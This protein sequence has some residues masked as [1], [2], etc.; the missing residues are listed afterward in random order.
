MPIRHT[1]REAGDACRM[2]NALDLVGDRW[3]LVL[4]RELLLGPKRFSELQAAALGI[5][6]AVLTGR[7]RELEEHG[8]IAPPP[9]PAAGR[10]RYELTAWGIALEDVLRAFG[11]WYTAGPDPLTDGSLTPDAFVV[12]LRTMAPA[13]AKIANLRLVAHPASPSIPVRHAVVHRLDRRL[14]ITP[15]DPGDES[16]VCRARLEGD[17]TT[18]AGVCFGQLPLDAASIT[19]DVRTVQ[20]LIDALNS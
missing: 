3:S 14:R 10:R 2:A 11:R 13:D 9:K 12:A 1:H 20:A 16:V 15:V 8:I 17:A 18:L 4:V 19:G 6:P 5:T 7:L